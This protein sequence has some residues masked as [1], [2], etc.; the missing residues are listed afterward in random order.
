MQTEAYAKVNLTL[1]IT[2]CDARGYH[3][4]SS[5]FA[6][7]SLSDTVTLV[8][9]ESGVVL[10]CDWPFI[11]VDE[12]NLCH[13]AVRMLRDE[14]AL[15]SEDGFRISLKKRI[16]VCA[17][18]GGGSSDAAAVIRLLCSH[19]NLSPEDPRVLRAA[20]RVGADVPFF[21]KGGVCLAEGV[22]EILTPQPA[23]R[24]YT[25]LLAKTS[26]RASTPEVY[27]VFD[28][29]SAQIPYTTPPFL[30]ALSRG[31]D[32]APFVSNH[33]TSATATLCPSVLRLKSRMLSLG[34]CAAEMSGSGSTVFGLFRNEKDAR[35]A[36]RKIGTPFRR[37]CRFI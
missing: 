36:A 3:L 29:Q 32:I 33:L 18:L 16:P 30:A 28:S 12:R 35:N 5:V 8:P 13:K 17:G 25:L 15:P 20:L 23:V 24:G 10:A 9:Q 7:V 6:M 26:E 21:L 19:Y 22:G 1:D 37:V 4:L 11:P 31:E 14:L 34:A 2:G 27:R